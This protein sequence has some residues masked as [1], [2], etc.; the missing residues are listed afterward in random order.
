MESE[1]RKMTQRRKNTNTR[2]YNDRPGKIAYL[3]GSAARELREG[4]DVREVPR[5][6][7]L[8]NTARKNREKA[9]HMNLG[10][11]LFLS[12][13]VAFAVMTLCSY[14][15]LQSDITNRV[16]A[17]SEMESRYNNLKLTNDEEYNRISSSLDLEQI[18]A[19]AIGELGMTYAREGQII[20]VEDSETDYVRQTESLE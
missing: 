19:V 3:E 15:D 6:K 1:D 10:Y 16:D 14:I 12:L 2:R 4:V 17:I 8:S 7:R 18:K 5:R 13:A 11:M 9:S 20:N